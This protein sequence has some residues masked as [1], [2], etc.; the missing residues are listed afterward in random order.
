ML[1][2]KF[3]NTRNVLGAKNKYY[4][5]PQVYVNKLINIMICC[6]LMEEN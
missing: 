3:R 2:F 1:K 6:K 5:F 4:Q